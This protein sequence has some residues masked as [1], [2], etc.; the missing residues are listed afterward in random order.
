[1]HCELL[2][3]PEIEDGYP[4]F[5]FSI[6]QFGFESRGD[7]YFIRNLTDHSALSKKTKYAYF[8]TCNCGVPECAG[9][10]AATIIWRKFGKATVILEENDRLF[11]KCSM[12]TLT[13]NMEQIQREHDKCVR[14]LKA[15]VDNFKKENDDNYYDFPRY[16][17]Y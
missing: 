10:E 13:F 11:K 5:N 1:M 16:N 2:I 4:I 9:Y 7:I 17:F 8:G 6:P 12:K 15:N 3:E 14:F